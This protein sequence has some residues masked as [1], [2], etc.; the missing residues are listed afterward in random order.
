MLI[1]F[2]F[3]LGLAVG[4]FI[5]A[6]AWRLYEQDQLRA[7]KK[8]PNAKLSISKGH[9]MC[10]HCR[11]TLGAKDL[12]PLLSWVSLKGRCRYCRAKL[13]WEYPAIEL[14]TGLLFVASLNTWEFVENVDYLAFGGW[15]ILLSALIFLALYD[16]KWLLLPNKIIYP[17]IITTTTLVIVQSIFFGGGAE[18]VRDRVLG[19][20]FAGGI[21]YLLFMVSDGKWIGGGDVKLGI[22]IG[23]TLGFSRSVLTFILAFNMA[24]VVVLPLLFMGAV[25][26]KTPI[27]F[28]PFLIS[29]TIVSALYGYEILQWYS[30]KFLYGLI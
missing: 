8:K 7:A 28:G 19:L 29:A 27:P 18:M 16:I 30:D 24:A 1:V 9:S 20:A 4:S 14:A 17:L 21:F 10:E 3:I 26:R 25:K 23:I 22:F 13:S 2:V 6:S 5:S 15:L 11:H 12:V